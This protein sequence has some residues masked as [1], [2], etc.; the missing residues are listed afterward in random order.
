MIIWL[1]MSVGANVGIGVL[2]LYNW[3]SP[4]CTASDCS[5]FRALGCIRKQCEIHCKERKCNCMEMLKR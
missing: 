4:L 3:L 2:A 1:V 5:N